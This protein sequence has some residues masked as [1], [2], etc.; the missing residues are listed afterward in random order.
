MFQVGRECLSV[1]M[2]HVSS[3]KAALISRQGAENWPKRRH[4]SEIGREI[5]IQGNVAMTDL[6]QETFPF[7][8]SRRSFV[9]GSALA[10]P[11]DGGRRP[12]DDAGAG[13]EPK[14]GGNLR[15]RHPLVA[16]SRIPRSIQPW[17]RQ[18]LPSSSPIAGAIRWSNPILRPVSFRSVR[19]PN[20][21]T[22][23]RRL[24]RSGRFKIRQARRVHDGSRWTAGRLSSET[25]RRH[26]G[27][28]FPVGCPRPVEFGGSAS[29]EV[30]A[31]SS[32]SLSEGSADLPLVLSDYHIQIQPQWRARTKPD[33]GHR[34][35]PYKLVSFEPGIRATFEKNENDLADDRGFVDSVELTSMNDATASMSR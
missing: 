1:E 23:P 11:D 10:G 7:T 22:P 4:S 21:V 12:L 3:V 35:G 6:R 25:I 31:T 17:R 26:S 20:P 28:R 8:L 19:S 13:E 14:R 29:M 18:P 24:P 16:P 30:A 33:G 9:Q 15:L 27:R 2:L 34:N 32:I 5:T